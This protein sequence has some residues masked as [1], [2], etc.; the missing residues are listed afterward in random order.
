VM[1][2]LQPARKRPPISI[3]AAGSGDLLFPIFQFAI[4]GSSKSNTTPY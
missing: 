3:E 1:W 2:S 4:K